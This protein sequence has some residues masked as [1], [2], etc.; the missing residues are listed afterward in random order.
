METVVAPPARFVAFPDAAPVVL[1]DVEDLH[2]AD[3]DALLADALD[4]VGTASSLA[5]L[6]V[7]PGS[8]LVVHDFAAS[9]GLLARN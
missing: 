2:D 6:V 7:R 9:A 4:P 8:A 3:L 5:Q 1:R